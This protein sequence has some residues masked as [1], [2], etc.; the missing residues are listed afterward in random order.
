MYYIVT[1][2]HGD[3][4]FDLNEIESIKFIIVKEEKDIVVHSN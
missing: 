2:L 4:E 1:E 3:L